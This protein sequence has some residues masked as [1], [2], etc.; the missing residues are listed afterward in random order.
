MAYDAKT[1]I[2]P[3]EWGSLLSGALGCY[4]TIGDPH[5]DRDRDE[6]LHER[7]ACEFIREQFTDEQRA[8]LD[9]ID[10]YWRA[11]AKK[12]NDDFAVMHIRGNRAT[13]LEGFVED[14]NG[15]TP[16]I[17]RTHWWWWPIT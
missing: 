14:E 1:P 10:A 2:P 12:F 17:P 16:V 11:N 3:H 5:F 4:D 6:T 13:E 8:E 15:A 7:S 9:Q